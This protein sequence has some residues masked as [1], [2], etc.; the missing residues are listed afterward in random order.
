MK[1]LTRRILA[2][3]FM[4]TLTPVVSADL[5]TPIIDNV[6]VDLSNMNTAVSELSAKKTTRAGNALSAKRTTAIGYE[7]FPQ[8]MLLLNDN[9]EVG[10][11][12]GPYKVVPNPNVL[13]AGIAANSL[14]VAP[15]SDKSV[16]VRGKEGDRLGLADGEIII[17]PKM[18][19]DREVIIQQHA[20]DV[21]SVLGSGQFFTAR[22]E[23]ISNLPS[24]FSALSANPLV[25]EADLSVNY[26]DQV[27]Y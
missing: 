11:T 7:F 15:F 27:P 10:E 6:L 19:S 18:V 2:A 5:N 17:K 21:T 16:V 26:F 24:V 25:E 12:L 9:E 13:P 4:A 20:I 22:V 3:L 14:G 8:A 23:D 1:K